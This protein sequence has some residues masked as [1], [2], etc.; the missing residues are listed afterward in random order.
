MARQLGFD[1]VVV[2]VE[3]ARHHVL[4]LVVEGVSGFG[5]DIFP[6]LDQVL[7]HPLRTD[8]VGLVVG[9]HFLV[10]HILHTSV[11]ESLL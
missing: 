5:E 4:G 2:C 3:R 9:A 10:L 8:E 1:H 7:L 11:V 6:A